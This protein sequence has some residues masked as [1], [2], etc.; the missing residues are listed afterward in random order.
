M[1][2]KLSDY[3][4]KESYNFKQT[5]IPVDLNTTDTAKRI[6]EVHD[7]IAAHVS[8]VIT[9]L[10]SLALI[11]GFHFILHGSIDLRISSGDWDKNENRIKEVLRKHGISN[12]LENWGPMSPERYGGPVGVI[13]CY[14]NLEFNSR[15]ILAL[16]DAQKHT[17]DIATKQCQERLVHNQWVHY[18]YI[19]YGLL[20]DVQVQLEFSDSLEW[21]MTIVSRDPRSIGFANSVLDWMSQEIT[22]LKNKLLKANI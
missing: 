6:A 18:L 14:N 5:H 9:E 13:L 22:K 1:I 21:L 10:E 12:D 16:I 4:L 3:G 7:R 20:N 17:D 15:L 19:Q 2:R 8:P 11:N